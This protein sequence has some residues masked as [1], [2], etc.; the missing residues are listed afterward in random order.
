M[1]T[2]C[3]SL[4]TQPVSAQLGRQPVDERPEADALHRA[5]DFDAQAAKR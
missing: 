4:M 3:V 1:N 2:P 5:V